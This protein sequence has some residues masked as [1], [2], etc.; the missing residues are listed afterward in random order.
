MVVCF[1]KRLYQGILILLIALGTAIGVVSSAS[2]VLADQCVVQL[3]NSSLSTTQLN[4]NSNIGIIVPIFV[5]CSSSTNQLY[6]VGD[7]VDTSTNNDLG[8]VNTVLTPANGAYNGQLTFSLPSS[9]VGHPLQISV[10]VYG[11]FTYGFYGNVVNG[12]LLAS[13]AQRVQVNLGNSQNV[14]SQY[15]PT[16]VSCYPN[17]YCNYNYGSCQS[18]GNSTV[19]CSGYLYQPM[20]G[21]IEIAIPIDDAP[22]AESRIYQYYT[23]QNFPSYALNWNWVT[24]TGQLYLAP[25][26]GPLGQVCPASS[27]V[28]TSISPS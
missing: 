13:A 18:T 6:A 2:P 12:P 9:I 26:I 27:I 1:L 14:T 11:G 23:L 10:S 3:G 8:S 28:V 21:C 15:N 22:W 20:T 16:P 25:E 5:S 4:Y 19:K 7:A 24:V 17:S